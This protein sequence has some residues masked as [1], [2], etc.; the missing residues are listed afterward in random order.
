MNLADRDA[1]ADVVELNRRAVNAC[2]DVVAQVR[3]A[4]LG[5]ATPCAAWSLGELL[6]HMTVQHKGF[7]AA[8]RGL[9]GDVDWTPAPLGP[10]AAKAYDRA[11]A[12]ALAAF[13]AEGA[14]EGAFLLPE[15]SLTRPLPAAMAIGFHFVDAVVHGWDV[16][17]ALGLDYRLAPDLAPA[18]L[19]AALA[20]PGGEH[21][22]G[23]HAA[24]APALPDAN[25]PTPL[26]RILAALG[27]S[28]SWPE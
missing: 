22:L 4:D 11:A 2:R 3:P 8:A 23:P 25:E 15:I 7:A 24:F 5:R 19:A 21:R 26:D 17:R 1:S 12:E 20:V 18:A 28:P 27:R 14:L 13:D 9:G 16:A 6:A 10:D